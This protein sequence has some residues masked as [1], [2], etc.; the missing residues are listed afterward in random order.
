M[1]KQISPL[2]SARAGF[3]PELPSALA[4]GAA[5]LAIHESP[6]PTAAGDAD[7]IREL[8]PRTCGLP[9]LRL[10][11]GEGLAAPAPVKVGVVLSGGQAPGGHNVIAGLFDGLK[12]VH[13][14]SSLLGFQ[15]GPKGVMTG[16]H[17][18]LT[19]DLVAAYRNTGGFDMIGSGR[20]KI[21]SEEQQAASA[22]TCAKLG[23]DGLVI[24]GGDDSNTN[25]A[26][27]A[28]YFSSRGEPISVL[29]VPKTIDGDLKGGGVEA[30]FGFDTATRVYASLVG[31]ICRDAASARKYWHFIRLM[32]RSASHVTLECALQTQ[33]NL[34]LIAEEVE[35]RQ[36]TLAQVVDLVAGVI[37]QRAEAG[38][39]YG[40]CLVPE[41]LIE[42]IP[43][44]RVL[45]AELN[46]ILAEHAGVFESMEDSDERVS[47]VRQR[48]SESSRGVF[49][50]LPARI[51][52][53]L[54]IDRDAHGNVL[55]SQ[56]DTELLLIEQV[57]ACIANWRAT[58]EFPGGF[59][60]QGHFFGYEGRCANPTDFD[61]DYTYALG[62]V[63]SMLTAAG[64]TGYIC[65]LG[66]LAA[67]PAEWE[68]IGVPMTSMMRI[69][70]RKGRQVPVIAK[71]LV[72][73]DAEPFLSFARLRGGWAVEDA[74]LFP[75]AIQYFGPDSVKA[76]PTK[77]L[78]LE[79]NG[80]LAPPAWL[81]G[82]DR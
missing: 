55:V 37:R 6:S 40:V 65:A 7:R 21:E 12:A 75:G 17:V 38:R 68:P 16:R 54:L 43:E 23:L 19:G 25:A 59:K 3:R 1:R 2:D 56:I 81:L 47:F 71:A 31:N 74:F 69:E 66:N 42:F 62:Y 28:E 32:G 11:P 77:T 70:E 58:G 5:G 34:A 64:R 22:E 63:A 46:R 60:A 39:H 67:P 41:G 29:G 57:S 82:G 76:S 30:S 27:L 14:E 36:L 44:V 45:I 33:V 80:T 24:V 51:Q 72:R 50:S 79:R 53:Q 8:F 61:A 73:T 78:M 26:V 48:L 15:G 9:A 10:V 35:Q 18:E 52:Q 4:A 49:G 13:P 20:D